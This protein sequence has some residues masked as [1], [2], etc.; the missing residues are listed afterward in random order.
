VT[1]RPLRAYNEDDRVNV[2]IDLAKIQMSEQSHRSH[3]NVLE[4]EQ[5]LPP[6]S[7]L[8]ILSNAS[9]ELPDQIS[10]LTAR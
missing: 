3:P 8:Q 1:T 9:Q 6:D 10:P 7:A 2:S 4:W 5:R